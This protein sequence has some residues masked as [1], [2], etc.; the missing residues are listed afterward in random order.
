MIHRLLTLR[1]ALTDPHW[2]GTMLGG[3]TFTTMR[4]L[5]IAAM[6]EPLEPA[7]LELFT[8]LTGR[9]EAPT[10][11]VDE[12]WVVAA[13]ALREKTPLDCHLGRLSGG[14]RRL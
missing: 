6:G 1:H 13:A 4:T 14:L 12:L 5:L 7:E 2:L 10:E 8:K 9:T 3:P 11:P